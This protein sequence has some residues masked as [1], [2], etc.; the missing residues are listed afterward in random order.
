MTTTREISTVVDGDS[1]TYSPLTEKISST[2]TARSLGTN[3][4]PVEITSSDPPTVGQQLVATSPTQ[5]MWQDVASSNLT[6]SPGVIESD[7]EVPAGLIYKVQAVESS[8]TL[9]ILTL[10]NFAIKALNIADG[11]TISIEPNG[12]DI[13]HQDGSIDSSPFVITTPNSYEEF[14]WDDDASA[15]RRKTTAAAS[16]GG[17]SLTL[18]STLYSSDDTLVIGEISQTDSS[19]GDV[20]LTIPAASHDDEFGVL[21]VGGGSS[22]PNSTILEPT[23]PATI[24]RSETLGSAESASFRFGGTYALYR[25]DAA[26]NDGDGVWKLLNYTRGSGTG[27]GSFSRHLANQI[28]DPDNGWT[29]V[30]GIAQPGSLLIGDTTAGAGWVL[31]GSEGALLTVVAGET[32]WALPTFGDTAGTFCEGDD[33]RLTGLRGLTAT[34]VKTSNYTA[35]FG[36]CVLVDA[37]GGNFTVTTPVLTAGYGSTAD[38]GKRFAIKVRAA[39][40]GSVNIGTSTSFLEGDSTFV[41]SVVGQYVEYTYDSAGAGGSGEWRRTALVDYPLQHSSVSGGSTV[42]ALPGHLYIVDHNPSGGSNVTINLATSAASGDRVGIKLQGNT[43]GIS[44]TVDAGLFFIDANGGSGPQT[45]VLTRSFD[46]LELENNNGYW[47]VVHRGVDGLY[48]EAGIRN[49]SFT[50]SRETSHRFFTATGSTTTITLPDA[51]ASSPILFGDRVEL[52]AYGHGPDEVVVQA[53]GGVFIEF[54]RSVVAASMTFNSNDFY[55]LLEW[56]KSDAQASYFGD[57]WVVIDSSVAQPGSRR[58]L[59]TAVADLTAVISDTVNVTGGPL[60]VTLPSTY[61]QGDQVT[62]KRDVNSFPMLVTGS[63]YV[64]NQPTTLLTIPYESMILE[65]NGS[66]WMVVGSHRSA[67]PSINDFRLSTASGVSVPVSDATGLTTIYWTPFK[68]NRIALYLQNS[69]W[70]LQTTPELSTTFS[71]TSG[72]PGDVFVFNDGAGVIQL[73]CIPWSNATTRSTSLLLQD[74][75]LIA[76]G[77]PNKRYLGTFLNRTGNSFN[78]VQEGVDAAVQL[79]LYNH[80]N[81][82]DVHFN[83]SSTT[84]SWAGAGSWAQSQGSANYQVEIVNGLERYPFQAQI[85]ANGDAGGPPGPSTAQT[86]VAFGINSTSTPSGFRTSDV[87]ADISG[88]HANLRYRPPVGA[89]TIAWLEQGGGIWYGDNGGTDL[90][91]GMSGTWR[92]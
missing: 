81:Q 63:A 48:R 1:I 58:R 4:D 9:I 32:A 78:W 36:E 20:T 8:V 75:V 33:A 13:E 50:A 54:T 14:G 85:L 52:I 88:Y 10:E 11:E 74:G 61:G 3:G 49:A 30:A 16:E 72:I 31:P 47:I 17:A 7:A 51:G 69:V 23:A 2:T 27:E 64:D 67:D 83:L 89:S 87:N 43:N 55:M 22:D 24:V 42:T 28:G 53:N 82:I 59:R 21:L 5:A 80:E 65:S 35:G 45:I 57:H 62:I 15:W 44:V 91:S 92:C 56:T 6:F 19:S 73:G 86:G 79:D 76:P 68:G 25:Y 71:F 70:E 29:N 18:N 41:T 77:A 40:A 37:S 46:Y 26:A 39:A 66:Q 38:N 60:T 12:S 34:S 90:L 84:N